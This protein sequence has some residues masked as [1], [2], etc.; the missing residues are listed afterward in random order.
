MIRYWLLKF[1]GML[2]RVLPPGISYALA[3]GVADVTYLLWAK[4]R[5]NLRQHLMQ[6]LGDDVQQDETGRKARQVLRNYCKYGVDFIRTP[7]L[8]TRDIDRLVTFQGW[9][10]LDKA[11]AEGK[12]AILVG[13]HLGNWDL[14]GAA[15]ASR[16][17]PLNVIANSFSHSKLNRAIQ[18]LR[19]CKGMRVIP[20]R[21]EADHM[22]KVLRRN[23][24]LAMLIDRPNHKNG[25][26]VNFLKR[27]IK[28]PAGAATLALRTGA[29]VLPGWTVRLPDNTFRGC[30]GQ[31]VPF[32]PKGKLAD[33]VQAFTQQIM[34]ALE[35][36]VQQYPE[37]WYIFSPRLIGETQQ[38]T[39][40]KQDRTPVV[41]ST[42]RSAH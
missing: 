22:V 19:T 1:L 27:R 37:Q 30:I 32:R 8:S 17:Y 14:G 38:A 9:E 3:C 25:V 16:R 5:A 34:A 26:T 18:R 7:N 36:I 35:N 11:L 40:T 39:L 12:G 24:L 6:V 41:D 33:D 42:R 13:L 28:V 31:Q 2:C 29:K 10:N 23:E 15:I 4:G 21:A 20:S